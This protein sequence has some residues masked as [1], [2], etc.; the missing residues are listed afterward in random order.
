MWR[1]GGGDETTGKAAAAR[2][3]DTKLRDFG[4]EIGIRRGISI[5]KQQRGGKKKEV[6]EWLPPEGGST[7]YFLREKPRQLFFFPFLWL[8]NEINERAASINR[9]FNQNENGGFH[10]RNPSTRPL[11]P[12]ARISSPNYSSTRFFWNTF[13]MLLG[14]FWDV[15]GMPLGSLGM[16]WNFG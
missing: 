10:G 5:K 9:H 13:R 4:T 2:A 8:N 7:L 11:P 1:S 12:S 15:F 3:G 6:K 16:I 14:C